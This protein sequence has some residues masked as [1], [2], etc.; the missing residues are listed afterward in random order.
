LPVVSPACRSFFHI[1]RVQFKISLEEM[2]HMCLRL[3][4][5]RPLL[6]RSLEWELQV[7]RRQLYTSTVISNAR[8]ASAFLNC[9][10]SVPECSH[11]PL[12]MQ[13]HGHRTA[14]LQ[15]AR[16][17]K[18]VPRKKLSDIVNFLKSL[19]CWRN[20]MYQM[21]HLKMHGF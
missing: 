19:E 18:V 4:A 20:I 13:Q 12:Y 9:H 14:P 15:T 1:V 8:T 10:R 11:L 7:V 5:D 17:L 6:W 3:G 21:M 16:F 2:R